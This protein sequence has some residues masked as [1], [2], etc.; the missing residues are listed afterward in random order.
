MVGGYVLITANI[1]RVKRVAKELKK[2]QGVKSVHVVT[3]PF[4]IIAYIEAPDLHS[5]STT[6]VENIHR[7]K[8]V[9]DTNT[10]VVVE[11]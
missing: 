5:L 9:V 4:D 10:A 7:V 3:G 2:I 1:G 6:I 11:F 8:G